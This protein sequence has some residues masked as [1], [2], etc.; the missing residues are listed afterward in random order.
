M[1]QIEVDRLLEYLLKAKRYKAPMHRS[2]HAISFEQASKLVLALGILFFIAM[3]VV[4]SVVF[5]GGEA[6]ERV[7]LWGTITGLASMVLVLLSF[8]LGGG[9]IIISILRISKDLHADFLE[10]KDREMEHARYVLSVS[11]T[12]V[13][14]V[15]K[16]LINKIDRIESRISGFMGR[17]DLALLSLAA[18][19]WTLYKEVDDRVGADYVIDQVSQGLNAGWLFNTIFFGSALV[20]GMAI[21]AMALKYIS[22]QYRYALEIVQLSFV[23]RKGNAFGAP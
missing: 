18:M 4:A 16:I 5:I 10:E 14:Y 9:S 23:L 1:F 21:G 8:V 22:R 2:A 15:E 6:S 12:A 13:N 11:E 7:K 20:F 19:G 3:L 17:A